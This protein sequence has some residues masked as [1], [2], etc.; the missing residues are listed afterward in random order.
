MF[1]CFSAF[2]YKKIIVP[3]SV[4]VCDTLPTQA[5]SILFL[6]DHPYL[7]NSTTARNYTQV[8]FLISFCLL[9]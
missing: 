6:Q 2:L 1:G 7:E 9:I 4:N 3:K 8:L 5:L